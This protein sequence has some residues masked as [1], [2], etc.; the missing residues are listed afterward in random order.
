MS[1]GFDEPDDEV[2]LGRLVFEVEHIPALRAKLYMHELRENAPVVYERLKVY[3]K[4]NGR[5]AWHSFEGY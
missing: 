3:C 5:L 1:W 4:E 2:D